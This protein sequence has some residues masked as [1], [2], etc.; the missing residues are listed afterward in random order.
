M[1]REAALAKLCLIFS[2]LGDKLKKENPGLTT[3]INTIVLEFLFC[4]FEF[5]LKSESNCSR[6]EY[7]YEIRRI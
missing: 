6:Q 1:L 3:S 2:G 4:F 7:R 5:E